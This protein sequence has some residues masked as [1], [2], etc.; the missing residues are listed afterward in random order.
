MKIRDLFNLEKAISE[1]QEE[2]EAL[3]FELSETK[4]LLESLQEE[5]I[6]IEGIIDYNENIMNSNSELLKID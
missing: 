3:K 1:K 2:L 5:Q 4:K 6:F